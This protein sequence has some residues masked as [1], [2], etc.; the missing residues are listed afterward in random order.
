V[1]EFHLCIFSTQQC[2][3]L[4]SAI[5]S[6][7]LTSM[8]PWLLK[9]Y[10]KC[11]CVHKILHYTRRE[12]EWNVLIKTLFALNLK[13]FRCW[14]LADVK[15]MQNDLAHAIPRL[16]MFAISKCILLSLLFAWTYCKEECH[17]VEGK[18][19]WTCF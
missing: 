13:Y 14:P 6:C 3:Q 8:T 19:T 7:W 16:Y 5:L 1:I 11:G 2:I 4:S 15:N 10:L 9:R 18:Q 12:H 17:A